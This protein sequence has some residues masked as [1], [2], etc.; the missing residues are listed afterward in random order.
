MNTCRNDL[1][2]DERHGLFKTVQ[3][4]NMRVGPFFVIDDIAFYSKRQL[5]PGRIV[6]DN[7][8]VDDALIN[9]KPKLRMQPELKIAVS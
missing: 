9:E 4:F 6:P 1:F 2:A 5:K 3:K 7:A 8:V